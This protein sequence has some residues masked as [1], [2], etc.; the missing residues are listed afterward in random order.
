[1][2]KLIIVESP[3]KARTI[4]KFVGKDFKIESSF[5][6]IRDLPKSKMGIDIEHDFEP[7]YL[8]PKDKSKHVKELQALAKKAD[9][10]ILATDED[11]EGEAISWHLVQALGLDEKNTKRIVFHEITKS[12]I[13][14]ALA[15]P[16]KILSHLVDAQQA[17]RILDRLVGYE[18]SP[19]LWT[20]VRFGLSAGR[21]QS[22]AV[23]LIVER[24]REIEKFKK[25]EYWTVEARLSPEDK[26][27]E[28][29]TA[30]LHA[31]SGKALKKF[32]I[33]DKTAAGNIVS[34][35]KGAAYKVEEITK[36]EARRSPAPPFTTSTLQQEAARKLGMSA[37]QTMMLAQKLYEL[38]YITYMR[39]DSVNLAESALSQ[40][41]DIIKEKF[42]GNY[43]GS[44]RRYKTKSKGAQEA[45][46]AIRPTD[47][48][49][50]A[51]GLEGADLDAK[52]VKLYDLIWKRSLASQMPEA[53]FDQTS[54]DI[55]A[56]PSPRPSTGAPSP[57]RGEGSKEYAFRATG[58]VVKFDG[59]M[60]VYTEGRDEDDKEE[61]LAEGELPY[62]HKSEILNLKSLDGVQHFTEPPPRFTD[63]SLVKALESYGIGRPST[64]APT[65]S[66][67]VERGYVEKLEKKFHPTEIGL[68]VNDILVEHFPKIVDYE[69]TAKMEAELDDIAEAKLKW[70]PVI[71]E[72]YE[73]FKENLEAKKKS[74]GKKIEITDIPCPI[75][76][77]PLVKKFG[78]FGQFMACTDYPTCKGTK[79]LPEEEAAEKKIKEENAQ[80]GQGCPV[81]EHG[82]L[83]V[84]KGR[85]GF[86]IGC[87]KYPACKHIEK[88]EKKIGVKC[89]ECGQ[90]EIIEKFS[91]K[92]GGRKFWGCNKYPECKYAT[93]KFP[94]QTEEKKEE[95][96]E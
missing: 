55:S 56:A 83:I 29:F 26:D 51:S 8:I 32:D 66:T 81:C 45:H 5:G 17:R 75:C 76:S 50:E 68:L 59:F 1:M 11:R 14:K 35:L 74:V 37:K 6:H 73:P 54:V 71:R 82:H 15:A 52:H 27:N 86:F 24:E 44:T 43:T 20:K 70:Q 13:E 84:K 30:K 77:K 90:G 88:I 31:I 78:R 34:D 18:L 58:Q 62:L 85:F 89:P 64:Y 46:E 22:V 36:K 7:E 10:V 92:K 33:P 93:W 16:R 47:L 28:T 23:R 80:I 9:E 65:I 38:G 53:I 2:S 57:A 41:Q 87:D 42:G 69:F 48:S 3:T 19:F 61:G 25:Q 67:I 79:Q 21:V 60:K 49:I 39:T 91:R 4:S 63:A 72:F 95:S 94:G 40:A 96:E 12:A